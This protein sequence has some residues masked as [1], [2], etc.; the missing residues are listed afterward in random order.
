M[1][2]Q[3]ALDGQGV[4]LVRSAHVCDD[5]KKGKLIKLFDLDY[6]SN[7]FYYLVCP[8]G[9]ENTPKIESARNW[10]LSEAAIAQA[11]YDKISGSV[12]S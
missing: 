10:L 11:D 6:L 2:L 4:A 5:L 9:T 1:A 12:S 7:V 8:T 3:A